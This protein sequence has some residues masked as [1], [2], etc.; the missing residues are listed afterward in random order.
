MK[1][2]IIVLALIFYSVPVWADD[3][4]VKSLKAKIYSAPSFNSTVVEVAKRGEVLKKLK[5]DKSWINVSY[6]GKKGWVS[7]YLLS[8]TPPMERV[9][10]LKKS[11]SIEK[12]A[13]RRASAITSVAAARGLNE[14]SRVRKDKK[15][16][17]V[18]YDAL[19]KMESINISENEA[20][21]FIEEGVGK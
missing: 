13:R 8:K 3:L 7:S 5:R 6:S 11:A 16:Y 20:L 18:D 17:A 19:D 15:S 9:S 1:K 14:Y 10:V 21:R 2:I 4:Y 12:N